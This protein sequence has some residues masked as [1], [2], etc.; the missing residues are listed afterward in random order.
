MKPL[1]LNRINDRAPYHVNLT[2]DGY[3]FETEHGIH[4]VVSFDPEVILGGMLAYW[5]NLSN[6]NNKTSPNDKK[7]RLNIIIIIEEFFRDNPNILLYICDNANNQ[8]AMRSRLFSHWFN[9]YQFQE[10]YYAR[11]EMVRDE[12]EENYIS[13]IVKRTHPQLLDIIET[14]DKQIA[15]F[16]SYKPQ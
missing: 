16:K 3:E 9:S 5:F 4:Y 8:Q 7:V 10:E 2:E 14:F 15:M 1:D 6:R 11:T 12:G 13:I